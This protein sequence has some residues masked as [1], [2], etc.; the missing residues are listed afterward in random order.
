MTSG[1]SAQACTASTIVAMTTFE[2][3]DADLTPR[4]T[5]RR[6][7][8]TRLARFITA[9]LEMTLA[10]LVGMGL[11]GAVWD[12]LWP[13]LTHR[14]DA[15]AV[16]MAAD[17]TLAMAA[18]MWVRG[19]A[20]RHILQMSAVMV[21][22]FLGLLWPYRLG[23]L[24]GDALLTGGHIGMFALMGAYLGWRPHAGTATASLPRTGATPMSRPSRVACVLLVGG[25]GTAVVGGLLHPHHQLPNSHVAVFNEYGHS[26]DWVWVHDLQFLSAALV[27]A[28]LL[29]LGRA[30]QRV[31]AAPALLRLGDAAAAATAALIAVNMAVDGVALKRAVDAWVDAPPQD[32]ASRF[33]A[34]ETVR[35]LE[36]GVN[37]Y[38]TILLGLTLLVFAGAIVRHGQLNAR[39]RLAGVTG[40]VAG[41]L[42]VLNG[43][44]VG[45]HGFEPTSL[46]LVATGLYLTMALGIPSLDRHVVSRRTFT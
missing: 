1:T 13:G 11:F 21:L 26:T 46:P 8:R 16:T 39:V 29:V 2:N 22:P 18:W 23:V 30:L 14:P 37:S 38:F 42:L 44:S 5:V 24:T 33:A 28:G 45:A 27:V 32:R 31:G 4:A 41:A 10:M 15:M 12:A 3:L 43:L 34:A 7:L 40:C 25:A 17:M 6:P 19:H 36:W 9:Y 35:W 20:G